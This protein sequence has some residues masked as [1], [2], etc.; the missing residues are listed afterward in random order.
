MAGARRSRATLSSVA[1]LLGTL[2]VSAQQIPSKIQS[3]VLGKWQVEDVICPTCAPHA[4]AEVGSMIELGDS[5]ITNAF[6][7]DCTDAPSYKLLRKTEVRKLLAAKG[8]TWP[9]VL[10][11]TLQSQKFVIYGY[12]TCQGGNY[13]RVIFTDDGRA[14]YF[15]EGDTVFKLK[16]IS[17]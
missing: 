6:G 17:P 15:W 5:K 4:R 3:T 8:K 14:Y 12:I 10:K 9:H 1:F 7:G 16:R 13:M 11:R 2:L